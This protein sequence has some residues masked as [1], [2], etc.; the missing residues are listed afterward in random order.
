MHRTERAEVVEQVLAVGLGPH[1]DLT[2]HKGRFAREAALRTGNT[3][4]RA[5]VAPL[6][7]AG[8]PVEGVPFGHQAG[9]GGGVPVRS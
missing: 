3:H 5:R 6:V 7:Q 2:V 9:R 1:H 8:E 4:R